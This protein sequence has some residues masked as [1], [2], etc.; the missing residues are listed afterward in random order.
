M[1]QIADGLK[2]KEWRKRASPPLSV[3]YFTQFKVL[4][5]ILAQR[6][7]IICTKVDLFKKRPQGVDKQSQEVFQTR[8]GGFVCVCARSVSENNTII[9]TAA[10]LIC[11]PFILSGL[12]LQ[13][14]MSY[15][16]NSGHLERCHTRCLSLSTL[17]I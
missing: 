5:I 9:S 4:M 17:S 13:P 6:I 1:S 8:V 14:F 3:S 2:C 16:P 11:W 12:L 7:I 15:C 10:C